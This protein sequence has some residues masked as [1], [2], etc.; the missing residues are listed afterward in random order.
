MVAEGKKAA[1]LSELQTLRLFNKKTMTKPTNSCMGK[2]IRVENQKTNMK[3]SA[4]ENI[5]R[6]MKGIYRVGVPCTKHPCNNCACIAGFEADV[7][8]DICLCKKN[9][10]KI[11]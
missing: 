11:R 6:H 1:S 10:E 9:Y 7:F 2:E 3:K 5:I 8:S 4:E